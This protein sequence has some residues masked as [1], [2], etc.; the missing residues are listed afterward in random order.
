MKGILSCFHYSKDFTFVLTAPLFGRLG[1]RYS[2]C[3]TGCGLNWKVN[4]AQ[5]KE[6]YSLLICILRGVT[7]GHRWGL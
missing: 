2:L 1:H 5:H 7:G 4:P 6:T 3:E